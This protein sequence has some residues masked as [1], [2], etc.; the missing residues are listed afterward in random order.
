[1]IKKSSPN[2]REEWMNTMRSFTELENVK[3][4]QT[5]L[6]NTLTEKKKA[7]EGINSRLDNTDEQISELEYRVVKITQVEQKKEFEK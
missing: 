5:E 3:K 1:M 2:S 4:N 6:K 7:L